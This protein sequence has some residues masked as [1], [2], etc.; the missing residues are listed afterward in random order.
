MS[1]WE[2][3]CLQHFKFRSVT[4]VNLSWLNEQTWLCSVL[5]LD[6]RW[7]CSSMSFIYCHI[8]NFKEKNT[9][10]SIYCI[11]LFVWERPVTM[12]RLSLFRTKRLPM[13]NLLYNSL[14]KNQFDYLESKFQNDFLAWCDQISVL[15][16]PWFSYLS[17]WFNSGFT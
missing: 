17:V 10:I 12:I 15:C 7:Y 14:C 5:F 9:V 16:L 6:L 13:D 2:I 4:F 11:H 3:K 8:M 1:I